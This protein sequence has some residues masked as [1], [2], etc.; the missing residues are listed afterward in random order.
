MRHRGQY[1]RTFQAFN[2]YLIR[3]TSHDRV[4]FVQSISNLIHKCTDTHDDGDDWIPSQIWTRETYSHSPTIDDISSLPG[5]TIHETTALVNSG[6]R[7]I[8]HAHARKII[9]PLKVE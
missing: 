4:V 5:S 1:T 7:R 2:L 9:Y 8:L 3:R 6:S